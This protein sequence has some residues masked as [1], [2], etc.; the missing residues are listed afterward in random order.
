MGTPCLT[1]SNTNIPELET[2]P[3]AEFGFI[4]TSCIISPTALTV[5]NLPANFTLAQFM[6]AVTLNAQY[7]QELIADLQA[8]IDALTETPS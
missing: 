2:T 4:P 6:T 8:Q 5:F 7:N 1:D 3:C